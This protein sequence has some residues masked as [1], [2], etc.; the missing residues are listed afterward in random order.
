MNW[1]GSIMN[2]RTVL[3]LALACSMATLTF[4]G[5]QSAASASGA[6]QRTYATPDAAADDLIKATADFDTS[7]LLQI[8]GPAGEDFVS[9]ADPVQDKNNVAAFAAL[10]KQKESIQKN[11]STRAT[12]IVG[13]N[14][15]PFPVPLVKKGS[16]WMFDTAAGKKEILY[17]RIGA[18]ELDAIQ[19]CK[20]YVEAQHEYA[21]DKHDGSEIN[22]YA[23]KII[24]TSGKQDGLYWQNADGSPGG[25]ISERAAKAIEEGYS[26]DKRSAYHGYYFK[27]L[28]G[29]GPNAPMGKLDYVIQGAM[30]G[31]FA[32]IAAPADYRVTGVKT[33]IVNQNGVVYQKDL[34]PNTLEIAKKIELY[35]PDKT[36]Q[37][38]DDEWPEETQTTDAAAQ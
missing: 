12:L 26:L 5:P 4:A 25:P 7:A 27:I 19:M 11:G 30:I 13:D 34:G 31:G 32:L 22:E 8:F 9:T 36:W 1:K 38:T 14:D 24:S 35:D 33:F 3:I 21:S 28:K 16:K 29:Q 17:R 37:R 2:T 18:N 15:W 23:Q 10:A 6:T 20:G